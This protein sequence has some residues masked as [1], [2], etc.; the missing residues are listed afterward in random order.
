LL[1]DWG[2][3]GYAKLSEMVD[4]DTNGNYW[5]FE[6]HAQFIYYTLAYDLHSLSNMIQYYYLGLQVRCVKD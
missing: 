1:T 4:V 5:V 2:T 3:G 6:Y